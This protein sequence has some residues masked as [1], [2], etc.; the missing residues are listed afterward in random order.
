MATA[1]DYINF[2]YRGFPSAGFHSP[3]YAY[4]IVTKPGLS[5]NKKRLFGNFATLN[6]SLKDIYLFDASYRLDGSS[7]FGTEKR[8][9]PFWSLGTG[10]NLHNT[11]LFGKN[12]DIS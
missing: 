1:E 12:P 9:A 6:Y 5:D 3:A 8:W 4:Q 11:G 7:E 10:V 2:D